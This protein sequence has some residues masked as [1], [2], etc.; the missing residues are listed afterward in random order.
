MVG[1]MADAALLASC[2]VE[3]ARLLAEGFTL[4]LVRSRYVAS[5]TACTR[6]SRRGLR[7]WIASANRLHRYVPQ[8]TKANVVQMA[9]EIATLQQFRVS[10]HVCDLM[11]VQ[12]N[13]L[14]AL[15]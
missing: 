7:S 1:E 11:F 10:A 12:Q 13:N 8:G 9:I 2:R 3:P 5:K 4:T 15:T 6:V 14:V